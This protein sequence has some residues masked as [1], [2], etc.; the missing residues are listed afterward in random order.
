[1]TRSASGPRSSSRSS[2]IRRGLY[3]NLES[4][5]REKISKLEWIYIDAYAGAGNH[6]SKTTGE[7]VEGAQASPENRA[8]VSRI[9]L[10][11][12]RTCP[13]DTVTGIAGDRKNVYTYTEDCNTVLLRDVFPRAKHAITGEHSACSIRTTST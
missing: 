6:L 11:R 9:S 10:H 2:R 3:E 13:I 4:T 7:V 8:P 1:M 5:K 12:H